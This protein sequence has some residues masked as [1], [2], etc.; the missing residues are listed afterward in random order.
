[1]V[2]IGP[3]LSTFTRILRSASSTTHDRANDR[4]AALLNADSLID[5]AF[6]LS[7]N[8]SAGSGEIA[9]PHH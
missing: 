7:G 6:P 5:R 4:N 9:S 2:A 1:L 8:S 3:G